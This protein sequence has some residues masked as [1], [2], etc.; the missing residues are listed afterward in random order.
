MCDPSVGYQRLTPVT[1]GFGGITAASEACTCVER[2]FSVADNPAVNWKAKSHSQVTG[3][4]CFFKLNA[5]I[6]DY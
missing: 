3:K 4:A 1:A 2:M 6:I 5:K